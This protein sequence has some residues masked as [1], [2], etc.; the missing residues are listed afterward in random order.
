MSRPHERGTIVGTPIWK[1][2]AIRTF[3]AA[4]LRLGGRGDGDEAAAAAAAVAGAGAGARSA[5]G[6]ARPSSAAVRAVSPAMSRAR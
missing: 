3:V 5:A 1:R 6:A 2:L 4:C